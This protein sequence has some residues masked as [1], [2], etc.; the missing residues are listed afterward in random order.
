MRVL[1]VEDNPEMG[2]RLVQGLR[3]H[4]FAV[5]LVADGGQ[6][7]RY[8]ATGVYDLLILDRM[9]PGREGIDVLRD[10]RATGVTAPAIFLTARGSVA[11][12]VAGLDA[13][14]DDYLVK[15]FSFAE[16]LARIRVIL[17]RGS[18]PLA[19]ILRMADLSLDPATRVV[20]RGSQRIDLSPKQYALLHYLMRHTGQVV[21]R[22]MI[23]EHVWNFDFDGLTN[24]VDVHI[25]RLRNKIDRGFVGY[26]LR[27]E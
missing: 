6:A 11:D 5:D 9:L 25:N 19:S 18:E 13:G 8:A 26:V 4:G 27:E 22:T 2:T 24:V 21:S 1:V 15:P 7:Y 3:E 23:Q 12:R 10:L 20:E 14:A 17:R 16:L